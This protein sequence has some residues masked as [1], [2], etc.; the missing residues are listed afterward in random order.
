MARLILMY[1]KQVVNEHPYAKGGVTIGRHE[2]NTI[3]INN[4]AVSAFHARI[5]KQGSDFILT[6]LQSTNGTFV[7]DERITS[8][9]LLHGD[10]VLIG[11]HVLLFVASDKERAQEDKDAGLVKTML[12][13][14][15]K[16][17]E[18]LSKQK[19]P[20]IPL[21]LTEKVGVVS[22]IDGS[23]LG[24]IELTKK[25]TRIGKSDQSEIK[26]AGVLMRATTATISRRPSGYV[27][28]F[29]GGMTK[30]KVNGKVVKE[31]VK[32]NE[33]DT[34]EIG[35]YKF[36]FYHKEKSPD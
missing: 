18:L 33:F 2:D 9:K 28:T 34:I 30:L 27:I 14:T 24:E 26:L 15:E 25:L 17:R 35:S 10:N 4:L 21:K 19:T 5:D 12:L 8:R 36:Q 22:F 7:N 16:Q 1:N 13:D 3:V 31:S 32:L 6:D 20:P 23:G 29:T 11:K